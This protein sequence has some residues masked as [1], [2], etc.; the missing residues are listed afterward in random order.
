WPARQR[1]PRN[2]PEVFSMAQSVNRMLLIGRLGHDPEMRYS[3]DGEAVTTFSLATDRP[4]RP[5]AE[6][7]TDWHRVVCWSTLAETAG[8]YLA[9]GRLVCVIG[10]LTYR[11]WEARDGQ[12]RTAAEVVAA[13]VTMLDR[14]PD[15]APSDPTDETSEARAA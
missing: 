9:K 10:R 12:R 5:G 7:A 11:T 13:E 15:A 3:N 6:P 14:R 2:E 4:V 8:Q 1:D